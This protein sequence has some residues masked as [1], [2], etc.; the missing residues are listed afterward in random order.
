MRTVT[1]TGQ[2][3]A[4]EVPDTVV[5]RVAASHRAA[6]VAE[7]LAGADSAADEIVAVGREHTDAGRI[8]STT[9]N[10]WPAYDNEGKQS[11]FEARHSLSIAVTDMQK[12]GAMLTELAGRV[13]DRLQVE[14]VS[15]EVG[16]TKRA[17]E[18]ARAAAYADA[19][20]RANHLAE[21]AGERIEGVQA[22]AEGGASMP[23]P[24]ADAGFREA[25]SVAIQPG[26]TSIGATL[27][28]TFSLV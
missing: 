5:V 15:L 20:A 26:E 21:L 13:G 2:G 23:M 4:R 28:V 19:V 24:M 3:T 17:L 7:A 18:E 10:L 8:Q 14:S 16:D 27:T 11:G 1:V 25:K 6:G 9:L 12:A 22:M